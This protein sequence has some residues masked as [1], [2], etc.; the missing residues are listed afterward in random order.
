VREREREE[1]AISRL[2]QRDI[3]GLE[4]LVKLYQVRALRL[5][6]VITHDPVLAEDIVQATFLKVYERIH[7]FDSSRAFGPWFF[8]IVANNALKALAHNNRQISLEQE[9]GQTDG[10]LLDFLPTTATQDLL[11][12]IETRQDL[13]DLFSQL[14]PAQR[15]VILLHYYEDRSAAEIA[16]QFGRSIGTVKRHLHNA[17]QRLRSWISVRPVPAEEDC[18]DYFRTAKLDFLEDDKR[19]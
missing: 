5:A 15:A 6:Y 13:L 17:R 10:K 7:Q 12:Q 4:E 19:A 9:V 1:E 16:N 3:S 18:N 2:K 11:E 14:S 8:K